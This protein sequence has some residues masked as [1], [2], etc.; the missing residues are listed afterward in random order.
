MP[1]P[2]KPKVPPANKNVPLAAGIYFDSRTGRF[3]VASESAEKGFHELRRHRKKQF[4]K[5]KDLPKVKPE[6]EGKEFKQIPKPN[7][8]NTRSNVDG[9]I[10]TCN[11]L[12][13]DG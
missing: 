2:K 13:I 11:D 3:V 1:D 7:F 5:E 6:M 12:A 9:I 8:T 10:E 4:P